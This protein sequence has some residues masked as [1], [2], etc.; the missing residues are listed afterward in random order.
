LIFFDTYA[1]VS[2]I[3]VS[4][5]GAVVKNEY[6]RVFRAFADENRMRVLELLCAGEQCACVLLDDL[7]ISQPTLSHHMKILCDAGVVTKRR[8]GKWSYY[9]IDEDGCEYAKRLIDA[10]KRRELP[11]ALRLIVFAGR[12]AGRVSRRLRMRGAAP[13]LPAGG[14]CCS[15]SGIRAA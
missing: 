5:K 8:V 6:I 2:L 7:H 14:A 12:L 10:L 4:L 13:G 9:A 3:V 15:S 1:I 11:G